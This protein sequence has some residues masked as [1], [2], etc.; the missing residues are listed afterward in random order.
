MENN[1]VAVIG[2]L[3]YDIVL[4]QERLPEIGETITVDGVSFCGGGK[5]AN[6]AVQCAKLGLETY[7]IGSVG[8]DHY[9]TILIDSLKK[10]NVKTDYIGLA[11]MHTG[12]GIVNSFPDGR[13]LSTISTGAN[14]SLTIEDIER[15]EPIIKESQ[16]VILQ[17]EI[18]REV[19]EYSIKLAKKHHCY[20]I[21]NAA[22][23]YNLSEDAMQLIDCFVVNEAEASFYGNQVIS[24]VEDAL[25]CCDPLFKQIGE[26]LIITLGEKG[27]ILYDGTNTFC[28]SPEKVNVVETTG[29]GDSYIGAIAYGLMNGLSKDEMGKFASKVSSKTVTKIGG[30]DAMPYLEEI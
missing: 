17:L 9:G 21:V 22:P 28:F 6:Q 12:L 13:L 15:A 24:T 26:L 25:H 8:N 16:I 2:S 7:M 30:Q 23:S 14:Y 19:V 3:N 20:V 27:S 5:G 10:Y 11:D 4:K 29:A 18:P 1:K